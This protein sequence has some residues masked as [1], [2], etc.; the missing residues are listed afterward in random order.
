MF[1]N[2]SKIIKII[3]VVFLAICVLAAAALLIAECTNTR[4]Y[5]FGN[6]L[7]FIIIEVATVVVGIIGS[8]MIYGFGEIVEC[9]KEIRDNQR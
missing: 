1:Q 5:I 2:C 9:V 8:V 6:L 7:T 4:S 3:A